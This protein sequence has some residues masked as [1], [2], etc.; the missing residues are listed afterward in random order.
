MKSAGYGMTN[1]F[2]PFDFLL[3]A[4]SADDVES[5][6][7]SCNF[8]QYI[9]EI[10]VNDSFLF[11]SS[12]VVFAVVVVLRIRAPQLVPDSCLRVKWKTFMESLRFCV[13]RQS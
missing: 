13:L 12:V 8:C 5:G 1:Y 4:V 6:G 3:P 7:I 2:P 10:E 11:L 9:R